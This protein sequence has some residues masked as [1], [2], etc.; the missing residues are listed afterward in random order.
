MLSNALSCTSDFVYIF[1]R[2][3]RFLFA[4]QALLDLWGIP[5]EAAVG[6]NF[7]DLKYPDALAERLQ[8]QVREVFESRHRVVDE[9]PYTSPTGV[10]GY[11]EYIF[12]PVFEADGA[13]QF[14]V[15]STREISERKLT[16]AALEESTRRL[17]LATESA[18]IG[19]WDWN[20]TAD[21]MVWDKRMYELYGI[22]EEDFSGAV[23]AWRNGLHPED[24][25][26]SEAEIAHALNGTRDFHSEFRVKWPNGE[27]RDIEAHGAV[28]RAPDGSAQRM[29]GVNWDITARKRSEQA[30]QAVL[31]RLTQS[32]AVL[33]LAQSVAHLGSWEL[34][35][36]SLENMHAN[37]WRWSDETFRILG[38]EP[39][40]VEA[41]HDTFFW[42]VHPGDLDRA[43]GGFREMLRANSH[44]SLDHRI[45]LPNGAERVVR[46]EARLVFDKEGK[47]PVK[48]AGTI[49]DVT[50]RR[51]VD[52]RLLE[53]AE[54]LDLARDAIM[55]RDM[56]GRIRYWNR[57]SQ[58]IYGWTGTEAVGKH[59]A[60]LLHTDPERYAA[61]Q[62]CML[63]TGE[64]SGELRE[65]RRDGRQ[66]VVASRWTLLSDH[67]GSPK[68]MMV[69]NSDIT[70]HKKIEAQ[71]LR[72]QRLD[73]LGKLASG[74]AHD[75]NN[76]LA[77]ILL[78]VPLLREE[79]PP[80]LREL[81]LCDLEG[82]ARRGAAIVSQVLTFARGAQGDRSLVQPAQ[83]IKEMVHIARE[84]FPKSI[85]V[86]SICSQE[87]WSVEADPTQLHQVL[88]N[89]CVNA[90]DAMPKGGDLVISLENV[91]IDEPFAAGT[92]GATPG[93]HI[94]IQVSD[95]GTGIPQEII[96]QIFD[97][98]FT[99]KELGKG[100]G[101][102]LSTTIGI[103]KSHGGFINVYSEAGG[104]TTFKVFIPASREAPGGLAAEDVNLPPAGNG[105]LLLLVDDE[106]SIRTMAAAILEKHGYQVE[107]AADGLEA[108]TAFAA[109]KETIR[110][111]ITDITMPFMD[112]IT[113]IRTLRKMKPAVTIIASTGQKDDRRAKELQAL[114]VPVC[115]VKPY[116]KKNLLVT[117]GAAL[118][119]RENSGWPLF[120]RGLE[121]RGDG[122]QER[123]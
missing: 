12:S 49:Q 80:S 36:V 34:D 117:V 119:S 6:R 1:D 69:I 118:A 7:F 40:G 104:G 109:R 64:W 58:S 111:V 5:L 20:V 57:G 17:A 88:M 74:V 63:E 115:L 65:K 108:I 106:H 35:L 25:E 112:G 98:F 50:E 23:D 122:A 8:R 43:V 27:V 81:I 14:I 92:P 100:T 18:Q 9:T 39:G 121:G 76:I 83:L 82:S 10:R 60:K 54:L 101:L 28:Q 72:A 56:E 11:Y 105:E 33:A 48:V 32:Q 87:P 85:H 41:S 93:P 113:L 110:A 30:L 73:S 79:L 52:E 86:E 95:T 67:E 55:V 22:R 68:S 47:R 26:R 59:A 62:S 97:P 44:Y 84:T 78:A 21:K 31:Q 75:L 107:V 70:E 16:L 29:I 99:T 120:A 19:I 13:V 90:R 3:G 15:G 53:Q 77:P 61:A 24:R 66:V 114:G 123:V 103:V 91:L 46:E 45:I 4:N 42:A 89:L 51:A 38:H 102:G 37:P 2:E 94:L 96:D 116:N 71:F